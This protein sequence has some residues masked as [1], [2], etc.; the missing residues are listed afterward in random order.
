MF[1]SFM[2]HWHVVYT[3]LYTCRHRACCS[4]W[5][6]KESD[7]IGQL[8][9]KIYKYLQILIYMYKYINVNYVYISQFSHTVVSNSLQPHGLQHTRLPCPSPTPRAYSDSC[10][11]SRWCHTTSSSSV[12]PFSSPLQSFQ[13]QDLF[14]SV[15]SLHQVGKVLE[16]Q[17]QHQ[18]FQWIFKTDFL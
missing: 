10:P 17:L 15:S 3:Y 7:M 8:N 1:L 4:P 13:H 12:A 11:S 16:F 14:K 6:Y 5:C 9:N 2:L 18:S